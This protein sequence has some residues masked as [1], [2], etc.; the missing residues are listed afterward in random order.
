MSKSLAD[1]TA[2]S[3]PQMTPKLRVIQGNFMEQ[4]GMEAMVFFMPE[5]LSWDGALNAAILA[6]FGPKLDEYILEHAVKPKR[7]DVFL[8]S[9][10]VSAAPRLILGILPKWDGGMDDEERAL[11]K[12]L[13]SMIE[14]A[15]EAGLRSIAFPA[16]GMGHKDYPIRKAARLTLSVLSTFPYKN[17]REIR[18]VCKSREI[19]DAY[20]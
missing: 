10:Q 7:G 17:L 6:R 8:I 18:L 13:R 2:T 12:C 9:E 15:E 1:Q 4:Q 11:K 16:L 5:E 20:S 3:N 19:F 14:A